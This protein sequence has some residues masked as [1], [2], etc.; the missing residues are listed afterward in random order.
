M[1]AKQIVQ[2]KVLRV[3]LYIRHPHQIQSIRIQH[4]QILGTGLKKVSAHIHIHGSHNKHLLVLLA[5]NILFIGQ[6]EKDIG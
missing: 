4:L 5:P 2:F 3:V 1:K 6:L